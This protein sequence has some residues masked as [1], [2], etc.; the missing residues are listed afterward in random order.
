MS[1]TGGSTGQ[2]KDRPPPVDDVLRLVSSLIQYATRSSHHRYTLDN[3][4]T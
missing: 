1:V 4:Q 3:R 2:I